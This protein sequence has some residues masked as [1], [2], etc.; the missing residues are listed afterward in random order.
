MSSRDAILTRIRAALH[1]GEAEDDPRKVAVS[2]RLDFPPR[3]VIPARGQL[4]HAAQIKL[5]RKMAESAAASVDRASSPKDVPKLVSAYLRKRNLGARLRM[6]G[7]K[8]LRAI[9][10]VEERTLQVTIGPSD[11]SH[12][13]AVSHAVAAIAESGTVALTS[14]RDNPTTLNF[15]P[16]HHIVIVNAEDITGDMETMLDRLRD[17]HGKGRMPRTLNFITG[18]SR[19]GDIEQTLLLG[20]HGPRA[21]HIIIVGGKSAAGN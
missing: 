13:V 2:A 16:E 6:G 9:P 8:R 20:A 21:L 12:E 5:F 7:D 15:L 1:A 19:S 11:G 18:P 3:G 10:W 14:G 17:R 4:G